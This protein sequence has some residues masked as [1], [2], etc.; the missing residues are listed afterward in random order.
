MRHLIPILILIIAAC[1][2]RA[3]VQTTTDNSAGSVEAIPVTSDNTLTDEE[4]AAGWTLLFDGKTMN[5]WHTYQ[6]LPGRWAI[7]DGVLNADSSRGPALMGKSGI[8]GS[9][10]VTDKNYENF[11][12]KVDWKISQGGNSGIMLLVNEDLSIS[13]DYQ[14]APEMQIMDNV[15]YKDPTTPLQRVG[16]LYAI[17]PNADTTSIKPQGLWNT[18]EL[19]KNGT[20]L[21]FILNG[22][23]TVKTTL[24]DDN[25]NQLVAGSRYKDAPFA[26]LKSGK[27][28]LQDHGY[29]VWFKNIKLKPL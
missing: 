12:L 6:N 10:M 20:S 27:I 25:W 13:E 23:T 17:L 22:K 9:S 15:N 1:N 14:S 2:E 16:A 3:A 26:K 19:I 11:H 28:S 4:K 21:E 8:M 18:S 29:K 7:E 24:W 5:G